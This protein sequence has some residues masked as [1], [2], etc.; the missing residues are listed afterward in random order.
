MNKITLTAAV[1]ALTLSGFVSTH[2]SAESRNRGPQNLVQLG[3]HHRPVV[4]SGYALTGEVIA[5]RTKYRRTAHRAWFR[6][7]RVGGR[8]T[9]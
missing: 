7:H 4:S 2:A 1:A 8:N 9:H 5:P 6:Q 3:Q